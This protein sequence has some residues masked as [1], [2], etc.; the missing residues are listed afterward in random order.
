[1]SKVL[2]KKGTIEVRSNRSDLVEIEPTPDGA[3]FKFKQGILLHITDVNMPIHTKDLMRN[4]HNGFS[5]GKLV[6]ELDNYDRPASV[7]VTENV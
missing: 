3:V 7:D 1:M 6:F 2:I 4:T 5:K